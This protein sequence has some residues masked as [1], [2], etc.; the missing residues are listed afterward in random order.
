MLLRQVAS[1]H[2]CRIVLL[3]LTPATWPSE[4]LGTLGPR[5]RAPAGREVILRSVACPP[6]RGKQNGKPCP[7]LCLHPCTCPLIT[8]NGPLPEDRG[9]EPTSGSQKRSMTV[10][11]TSTAQLRP[12]RRATVE[13]VME[14]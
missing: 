11:V 8:Q 14:T 7:S 1:L 9:Y 2:N 4:V 10:A 6:G 12:E 3:D 5:F 13:V